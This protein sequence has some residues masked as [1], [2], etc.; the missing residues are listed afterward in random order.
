MISRNI[1]SYIYLAIFVF[2]LVFMISMLRSTSLLKRGRIPPESISRSVLTPPQYE[3][4]NQ[5]PPFDRVNEQE[6]SDWLSYENNKYG[7]RLRYPPEYQL[8]F[9]RKGQWDCHAPTQ[10]ESIDDEFSSIYFM[11]NASLQPGKYHP[12]GETGEPVASFIVLYNHGRQPPSFAGFVQRY[13]G[14]LLWT[15]D[16]EVLITYSR[17]PYPTGTAYFSRL[18]N[19]FVLTTGGGKD[20]AS[21]DSDKDMVNIINVIP[22]TIEFFDP[23]IIDHKSTPS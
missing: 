2:I 10:Y 18:E 15:V 4:E 6:I 23:T 3:I 8:I 16:D 17:P 12:L 22:R 7:F 9:C 14:V 21:V 13:F 11:L 20:G 1:T 19:L 5:I